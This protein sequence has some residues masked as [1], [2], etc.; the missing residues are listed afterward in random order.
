MSSDSQV[1]VLG[2]GLS[3]LSAA[4]WLG[5]DAGPV[6]E[7]NAYAGGHA[8]SWEKNG[9]TWD[10]G[11]HVQFGK[12]PI[13]KEFFRRL[14]ASSYIEQE[15]VILNY[16]RG[17]WIPH[18][19]QVNL[20][21]APAGERARYEDSL[22]Q[23]ESQRDPSALNGA[24]NYWEWLV[25]AYGE[26]FATDFPLRYTKKYWTI[27]PREMSTA[28]LGP[29]M[30]L[31][32]RNEIAEGTR[33]NVGSG[34]HYLNRFIYPATGGYM[35]F[36]DGAI[37]SSKVELSAEVKAIDLDARVVQ[38][39]DGRQYSYTA[40][41]NTIS[42]PEFIRLCANVPQEVTV[43]ADGLLCSELVLVNVEIPH[44]LSQKFHWCY[45]YDEDLLSTRL[46]SYGEL[47]PANVPEGHSGLQVEVY[48]SKRRPF[49]LSEQEI[50]DTVVREL[51]Q[52]GLVEA[53]A[54]VRFHTRY[55][56]YANVV[57][58][59]EREAH[60]DVI[61]SWLSEH[62]LKREASDLDYSPDWNT[63]QVEPLGS[64]MMAGRFAQWNF[65]WTHDCLLRGNHL[66]ECIRQHGSI[67][68]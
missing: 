27:H 17:S 67:N 41:I 4:Y 25:A 68:E 38:L 42:L 18:P 15:S 66:A 58:E 43:A 6:L 64:V 2:G 7:R 1:L 12:H 14:G 53:G 45:V 3:G 54:N 35:T 37:D 51:R 8:H 40:L 65:F 62:G 57:F 5:G 44:E 39:D 22:L 9:F 13:A 26:A 60:L 32:S 59:L 47:S 52:M 24:A 34:A 36:F 11:P 23:A 33:A 55:A 63:L 31:P 20:F 10:E 49:E 48:G 21:H 50:G 19:A 46:T 61:W 56:K 28:W 30:H 29:R 16:W